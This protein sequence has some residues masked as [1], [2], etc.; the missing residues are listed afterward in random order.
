MNSHNMDE[1]VNFDGIHH[2]SQN[3]TAAWNEMKNR[4][5]VRTVRP[6]PLNTPMEKNHIR[7]VCI[8]DT[9]VKTESLSVP[10]GDVLIH[11]GDFTSFGSDAEV[12]MF[13]RFLSTLP[14]TRKIV[15]A[16]NHELTFDRTR[17]LRMSA[18]NQNEPSRLLRNCEYLQDDFT[19]VHGIKIYGSPWQPAYRG[20]AFNLPR[21]AKCM[22][23]WKKIPDDTDVLVTHAPPVGHGDTLRENRQKAGCVELLHEVQTR[24]KPKF[25][26]FGHIHEGYGITTDDVTTYINASICNFDY[27]PVNLPIIFDIPVQSKS[28]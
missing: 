14:H 6:L 19:T 11:A 4:Q 12:V 2:L 5:V 26:V 13:D 23:M 17:S 24:V 1:S 22:A 16:G 9:H 8:S 25:H 27:E 20:W 15:I 28:S 7:F 18:K 3:P 10:P 21:G